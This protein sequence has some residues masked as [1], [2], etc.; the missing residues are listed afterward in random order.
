MKQT[1][2]FITVF[3]ALVMLSNPSIQAQLKKPVVSRS[4]VLKHFEYPMNELE[5]GVFTMG[6][7]EGELNARPA[8][9]VTIEPFYIGKYEVS[10]KLWNLVMGYNP[11]A[12]TGDENPNENLPV[13][14]IS[15]DQAMEF[16]LK[17]NLITH[18]T[19]RLPTEAEWEFAAKD[20]QA[21]SAYGIAQSRLRDTKTEE[22]QKVSSMVG[23]VWEWCLDAYQNYPG[24]KPDFALNNARV[25]R[26]GSWFD[27]EINCSPKVRGYFDKT[28]GCSSLGFRLAKT[29]KTGLIFPGR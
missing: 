16:I 9:Q 10:Q 17:L 20:E 3:I 11:S 13:E 26:G 5:G 18:E 1:F 7:D 4:E 24:A 14:N 25:I 21:A 19:Y 23:N 29:K 28:S 22:V 6:S 15:W 12:F 8:H 27:N 2:R